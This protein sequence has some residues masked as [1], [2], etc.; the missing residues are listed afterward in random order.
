MTKPRGLVA[1]LILAAAVAGTLLV[2]LGGWSSGPSMPALA[3]GATPPARL[4]DDKH[5]V[6]DPMRQALL[7]RAQVWRQPSLPI[8][9]A[10]LGG[11]DN[12]DELECAFAV[13]DLGGTTPKFDCLL[14][15]GEEIRIKY[16]NGPE[17]PAEVAATRLLRALGFGA[18]DVV[19]VERL[20]CHGCPA[21]PF[22]VL[23]ATE[24]ARAQPLLERAIDYD[25]VREYRWVA[26]ERKFNARPVET[27]TQEGW[28]FFE[29][30]MVD[31]EAGGAPRAHIDALR[32]MAVLLAHWDNKAQNQRLVC[33]SAAWDAARGC[34]SPFL[35]M[36]DVGATFGPAKV[37]LAAWRATPIWTDAATCTVSMRTLPYDGATFGEARITEEGRRF[38]ASLLSR[39]SA[40]QID[41]LFRGAGF[42]RQR[43]LW[44]ATSMTDEWT[45]AFAAK[46]AEIVNRPPCP[47]L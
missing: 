35:I 15:T 24:F 8:E 21:E 46:V 20:R 10:D 23:K 45:E 16:G 42:A 36:Q 26:L 29:L 38:A 22:A 47:A 33:L 44:S 28:A 27:E 9:Q 3:H 14:D 1:L 6:D 34:P 19:L 30:A 18:D 11:E 31:P 43:G 32:L 5:K 2:G 25:E 40:A 7:R 17:I 12:L 4:S 37:D 41:A 39:L 13:T